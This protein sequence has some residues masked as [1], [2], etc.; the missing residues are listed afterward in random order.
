MGEAVLLLV[1]GGIALIL[2]IVAV[3]YLNRKRDKACLE[4]GDTSANL[5]LKHIY[6]QTKKRDAVAEDILLKDLDYKPTIMEKILKSL[7][8]SRMICIKDGDVT[9][10]DFGK[11]Y[12]EVF[13]NVDPK[14][15][16]SL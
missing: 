3:Q 7:V 14:K 5:V 15:K 16:S 6:Y 1:L 4:Q 9:I 12:A 8:D 10:T 2:I 13:L 11:N